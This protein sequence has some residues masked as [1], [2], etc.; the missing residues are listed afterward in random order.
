MAKDPDKNAKR[1]GLARTRTGVTRIRIWSDNRYTTK[2]RGRFYSIL[3]ADGS[4]VLL[5]SH[6]S[7]QLEWPESLNGNAGYGDDHSL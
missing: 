1:Q 3:G 4:F 2:P 6:M 5:Y 7:A